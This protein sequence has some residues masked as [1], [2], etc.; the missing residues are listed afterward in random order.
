MT[1]VLFSKRLQIMAGM[2]VSTAHSGVQIAPL[3]TFLQPQVQPVPVP[4]STTPYKHHH[5]RTPYQR[6]HPH[7][8][9]TD[10]LTCPS[11]N[12]GSCIISHHTSWL[13][14]SFT[15]SMATVVKRYTENF[16]GLLA[17]C[18]WTHSTWHTMPLRWA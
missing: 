5:Q 17:N 8:S 13:V 12:L 2:S 1:L 15:P 4:A 11:C 10:D 18:G 7:S 9:Q 16:R 14:S 3:W 6:N